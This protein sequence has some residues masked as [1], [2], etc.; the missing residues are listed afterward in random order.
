MS[1]AHFPTEESSIQLLYTL[2][3]N[4]LEHPAARA[5]ARLAAEHSLSALTPDQ[6]FISDWNIKPYPHSAYSE[7]DPECVSI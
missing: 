1:K 5:T 2:A 7:E 6:R 4:N 3:N